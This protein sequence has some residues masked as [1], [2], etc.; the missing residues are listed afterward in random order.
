M[1]ILIAEDEPVSRRVLES[2]LNKWGYEVIATSDGAEAWDGL[3]GEDAP[4]LAIL[5]VNMPGMGGIE[6]C[7]RVRKAPRDISPYLILLTAKSGKENVVLGL[8]AGANDYVAKPFDPAELRAR[9]NVGLQMLELQRRLAQRV[10]ELEEALSQVKQLRGLLPICSYCKS[11]RDD[12]NYWQRVDNYI[13]S[14]SNVQFSHGICPDC[15]D[16]IVQPKIEEMQRKIV[17]TEKD[18][19]SET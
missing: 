10:T 9:V 7:H 1:R 16:H 12:G 18:P 2:T 6:V 8:E 4:L 15:Y 19:R 5:D 13:A 3:Q 14:H 11:I 17:C